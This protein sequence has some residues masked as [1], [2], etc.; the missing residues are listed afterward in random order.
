MACGITLGQ[1]PHAVEGREVPYLRVANVQDGHLSLDSLYNIRATEAEIGERALRRG[2]LVLTE[3]GD[4]DK[5]GRG[6][7]WNDEL[8]ECIY[9]N[10]I[11]RVRL[12]DGVV[13]HQFFGF[14]IRCAY[15]KAI[16]SRMQNRQPESQRSTGAFSA[17]C[18]S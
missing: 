15:A 11:F 6:T 4:R 2:D 3:G 13:D 12:H 10:H 14:Q 5:L 7:W 16:S 18:Q 8:P 9:Q 17:Q 1:R